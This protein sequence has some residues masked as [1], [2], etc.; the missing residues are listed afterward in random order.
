MSKTTVTLSDPNSRV[1]YQS[2]HF[3]NKLAAIAYATKRSHEGGAIVEI[4]GDGK[5]VIA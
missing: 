5:R 2:I 4:H 3:S 1:I